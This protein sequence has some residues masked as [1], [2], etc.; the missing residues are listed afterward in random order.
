MKEQLINF[1]TAKLAK[2]KG[3]DGICR[4]CYHSFLETGEE[5]EIKTPLLREFTQRKFQNSIITKYNIAAPTQSLLQ[6]WLREVHDI[7]IEIRNYQEYDKDNY[8]H[9]LNFT[10]N[11]NYKNEEGNKIGQIISRKYFDTYEEAL[12]QGLFEGLKLIK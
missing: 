7:H 6:K 5:N 3:F 4:H 9:T 11:A 1:E 8:A 10:K 2:E 12:E